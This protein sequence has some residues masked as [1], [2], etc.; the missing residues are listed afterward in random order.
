M[1]LAKCEIPET[2]KGGELDA[3]EYLEIE[4]D[5]MRY[6]LADVGLLDPPTESSC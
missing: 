6:R 5:G 1:K 2:I 3:V 4:M